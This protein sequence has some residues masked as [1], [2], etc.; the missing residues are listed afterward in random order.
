MAERPK[1]PLSG[2][3]LWLNENRDKIKKENPEFKV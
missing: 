2:Y 3:M 1:R